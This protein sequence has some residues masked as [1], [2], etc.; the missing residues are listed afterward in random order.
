MEKNETYNEDT[1]AIS[2]PVRIAM[3]MILHAGNARSLIYKAS[4]KSKEFHFEEAKE[5]MKQAEEELNCAHIAQTGYIQKEA[6]GE[7][8]EYSILFA[9]AQDTLMTIVSEHNM[10]NQ[11]LDMMQMLLAVIKGKT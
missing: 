6:S 2:E 8:M 7:K 11:M 1:E 5:L 3:D 4:E 9:H 10:M